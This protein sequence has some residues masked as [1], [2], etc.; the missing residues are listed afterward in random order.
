MRFP[1]SA[2]LHESSE[3]LEIRVAD[4][5]GFWL[6][7]SPLE[8]AVGQ[9]PEPLA[10]RFQ[11][12]GRVDLEFEDGA[13]REGATYLLL[14]GLAGEDQQQGRILQAKDT[15]RIPH[16]SPGK[17]SYIVRSFDGDQSGTL[18]LTAGEAV[19][20]VVRRVRKSA[21]RWDLSIPVD[22]GRSSPDLGMMSV[23][24]TPVDRPQMALKVPL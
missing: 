17:Y 22:V 7:T 12:T 3:P 13:R 20:L 23:M 11:H 6:G 19:G 9:A 8:R 14:L 10:I 21:G 16:V 15:Q 1:Y 18:E 24:V 4:E 2:D 5:E